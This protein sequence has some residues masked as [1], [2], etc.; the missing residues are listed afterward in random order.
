MYKPP[1]ALYKRGSKVLW[2]PMWRTNA[3][4]Q[5]AEP[6]DSCCRR[7]CSTT[8]ERRRVDGYMCDGHIHRPDMVIEHDTCR[9][10][11]RANVELWI[12]NYHDY[13]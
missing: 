8:T 3:H 13:L 9:T 2:A 1:R 4:G 7:L 12:V 6:D 11:P 5:N 10:T